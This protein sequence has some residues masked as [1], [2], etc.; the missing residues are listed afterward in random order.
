MQS[1]DAGTVAERFAH[2]YR[3][4]GWRLEQPLEA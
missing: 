3:M 2:A 1:L 4:L